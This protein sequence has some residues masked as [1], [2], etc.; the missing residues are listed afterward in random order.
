M[1]WDNSAAISDFENIELD[2]FGETV[3]YTPFGGSARSLQAVVNRSTTT[4]MNLPRTNYG[5]AR[6][7]LEI[8]VSTNHLQ[9]VIKN[10]DTVTMLIEPDDARQKTLTVVGARPE[11]GVWRLTLLV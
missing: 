8:L 7:H 5:P 10:K 2:E 11:Y 4:Q 9:T 3:T 1:A 6:R